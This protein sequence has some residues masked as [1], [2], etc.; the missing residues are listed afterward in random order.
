MVYWVPCKWFFHLGKGIIITW[1]RRKWH[2][3]VQNHI[4]LHDSA[5]SHTAA[6]TYLLHRWQW[7]ILK[8]SPFSP[9]ESMQLW[10][11]RQNK[12]ITARDPVQHKRWTYLCYRA[13]N[14]EHQ[15][16]GCADGVRRLPNIW[17]KVINKGATI[18]KIHKCCTPVNKAES[19]IL[20]CCRTQGL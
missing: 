20:K 7:E 14:M 2:L 1:T 18:L 19:E 9:D 12:R 5:R 10:S 17:Q 6:V 11:L 16:N 15:Q 4:I 13:V 8:H 3:V